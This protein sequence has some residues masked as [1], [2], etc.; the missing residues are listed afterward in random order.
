MT[1]ERKKT[2]KEKID[3]VADENGKLSFENF[4]NL[5]KEVYD[6]DSQRV[7]EAIAYV[8]SNFSNTEETVPISDGEEAH[9]DD[10]PF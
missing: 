6:L 3:E 7:D 8:K 10:L 5:A 4:M 2:I 9:V 1:E